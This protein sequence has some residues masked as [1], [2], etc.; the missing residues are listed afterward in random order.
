MVILKKNYK[1]RTNETLTT[2]SHTE[3]SRKNPRT[4]IEMCIMIFAI[5]CGMPRYF[6]DI[7]EPSLRTP[8][9]QAPS[10]KA[11]NRP[12]FAQTQVAPPT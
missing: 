3:M 6:H 12:D 7:V 4:A 9:A 2:D 5:I 1:E 11:H 8:S 10:I